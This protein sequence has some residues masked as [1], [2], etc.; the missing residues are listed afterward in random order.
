MIK[1]SV[2][3]D[4]S[5]SSVQ[6][7][8]QPLGG[9]VGN[10][11]RACLESSKY[12]KLIIVVAFAKNSGVLRLKKSLEGFRQNGA[13]IEVYVG[14]D[15]DGT[16]YEALISLFKIANKLTVVHLESGQTFHPKIYSFTSDDEGVLIV[17]SNNLTSGGLWTNIEASLVLHE[18]NKTEKS[19]VQEEL[20]G[21]IKQLEST[22]DICF[23]VKS[24]SDIDT[25][26]AEGY[27]AKEAKTRIARNARIYHEAGQ[28][29]RFAEKLEADLPKI[30]YYF[31]NT[32]GDKPA[33]IKNTAPK[34]SVPAAL[35]EDDSSIMWFETKKMTGGS[36]NILDLSK[37]AIVI[38]GDPKTTQFS[39][40]EDDSM[41]GGVRFFGID[42]NDISI[43]KDIV[44]NYDGIDYRGNT[45]KFTAGNGSWR[46]QIKG[47]AEDGIRITEALG[48]EYLVNRIITFTKID[49]GYYFM[50]VFDADDME[51]F[52]E[53][54]KIVAYNGLSKNSK[55]LGLL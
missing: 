22:T 54:S 26:L 39:M 13:E 31:I 53:V 19:E 45:I 23:E 40:G 49:D 28:P 27:I 55:L 41:E 6:L 38:K 34:K 32:E 42:P 36:R 10:Y 15:L 12:S 33:P 20:I 11:L 47:R 9:Q 44:I 24:E 5:M 2:I 29:T 1:L 37:T 14:I 17:G 51:E 25:L 3:K 35:V 30:E 21:Y 48:F 16:S 46:L 8:N 4:Y 18:D 43:I 52:Q 50:A 7:M